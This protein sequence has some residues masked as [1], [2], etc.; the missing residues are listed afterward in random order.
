MSN[1]KIDPQFLLDYAAIRDIQERYFM[2]VDR[3]DVQGVRDCFTDDV[4]AT[5]HLKPA[6]LR[7]VLEWQHDSRQTH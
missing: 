1:P 4:H 5:Y 2:A 3:G 7:P 6:M